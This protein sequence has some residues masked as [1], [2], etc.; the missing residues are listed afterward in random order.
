[1]GILDTI[2]LKGG[3][4]DAL[5]SLGDAFLVQSGNQRQYE[6]HQEELSQ[7]Q[8][9]KGFID[10]PLQGIQNLSQAG[11]GVAPALNMFDQYMQNLT[12]GRTANSQIN[13]DNARLQNEQAKGYGGLGAMAG[14]LNE[15]NWGAMVPLMTKFAQAR[16]I[17]LPPIPSG[18]D[19]AWAAT[20][21]G[22][23]IAPYQ[24]GRLEQF[25]E[26]NDIR[27]QMADSAN[28]NAKTNSRNAD[29]RSSMLDETVRAHQADEEI[30][31]GKGRPRR[32]V[33]LS[34]GSAPAASG[35]PPYPPVKGHTAQG[36]DGSTWHADGV[37]WIKG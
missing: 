12:R 3:L 9:L 17:Q 22:L 14:T 7:Q 35:I 24:Q 16:G 26:G 18:Y 27:Q 15:K 29:T 36:P 2:G 31:R 25:S 10:N 6:P 32:N 30:A 21:K 20:V 19:P 13:L 28:Q 1:M 37:Q 34:G 33:P 5:G 11:G 8:A 4:R 23:G